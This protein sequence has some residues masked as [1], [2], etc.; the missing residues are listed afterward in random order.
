MD[1]TALKELDGEGHGRGW[2]KAEPTPLALV[3][4][5]ERM[6][7]RVRM[8]LRRRSRAV[9][10]RLYKGETPLDLCNGR[11]AKGL[12]WH[13]CAQPAQLGAEVAEEGLA[14]GRVRLQLAR[15]DA[16]RLAH[17]RGAASPQLRPVDA[18]DG[19]RRREQHVHATAAARAAAGHGSG[20][21]ARPS[22]GL[23]ARRA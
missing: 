18:D 21:A 17:L 9:S 15:P 11:A 22:R 14:G 12:Q 20:A 2:P 10:H 7:R 8:Q 19:Q 3:N 16:Q 4:G 13:A 23:G 5:H 1:P 6:G